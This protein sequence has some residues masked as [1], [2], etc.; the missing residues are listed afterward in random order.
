MLFTVTKPRCLWDNWLFFWKGKY[1]LYYLA[2][3]EG[4]PWDSFGLAISDDAVHWKDLGDILSK[5]PRATWMGTG[6][7][8]KSADFDE[9]GKFIINYSEWHGPDYTGQQY[10]FFAESADLIHWN[11]VGHRFGPDAR[12]YNVDKGNKSRWDAINPL[13][14]PGGGYFGFCTATPKNNPAGFGFGESDDGARWRAL[15]PPEIDWGANPVP[16]SIESGGVAQLGGKYYHMVGAFFPGGTRGMFLL[17]AT[18]PAG[19]YAAVKRNFELL[20]SNHDWTYFSRFFPGPDGLLVNHQSIEDMSRGGGAR[21]V[22]VAPIKKVVLDK[23]GTFL[24]GYWERTDRLKGKKKAVKLEPASKHGDYTTC[25]FQSR[26]DLQAGL[27]VDG[28]IPVPAADAEQLGMYFEVEVQH[29]DDHLWLAVLVGRGGNLCTGILDPLDN[30]FEELDVVSRPHS[31][32]KTARLRLLVRGSLVEVYLAEILLQCAT[33]PLTPTG[34]AGF[35]SRQLGTHET[36]PFNTFTAW[37][38]KKNY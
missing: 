15:P 6:H 21:T 36:T 14:R 16:A 8:W 23:A 38:M 26:V 18:D 28:T 25:P 10:I 34:K 35:V 4:G 9:D 31:F 5:D 3:K 24:L 13:P 12:W 22:H 7:V 30:T 32:G 20:T 11:K 1:Y 19:P 17:E 33:M 2:N 29:V 37:T 27:V